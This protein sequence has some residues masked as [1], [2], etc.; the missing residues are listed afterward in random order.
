MNFVRKDA[1]IEE[2]SE[3]PEVPEYRLWSSFV[4]FIDVVQISCLGYYSFAL[5]TKYYRMI[6]SLLTSAPTGMLR[7]TVQFGLLAANS[8]SWDAVHRFQDYATHKIAKNSI[9]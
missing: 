6:V 5:P 7:R 3:V 8:V 1:W 2:V 9:T 4:D